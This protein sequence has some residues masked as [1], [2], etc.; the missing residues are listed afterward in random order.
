VI[1]HGSSWTTWT[2]D[3]ES[4]PSPA[5]GRSK[6]STTR[7][8]SPTRPWSGWSTGPLPRPPRERPRLPPARAL[9]RSPASSSPREASA[10]PASRNSSSVSRQ[11]S[12]LPPSFALFRFPGTD[13]TIFK[14]FSQ[15]IVFFFAQ[16]T[17]SFFCKNWIVTLV[18]EKNAN[19]LANFGKNRKNLWS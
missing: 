13:V 16:T 8:P 19:V 10:P 6:S 12:T 9:C 3:P 4:C 11:G 18:F 1:Q 15:K 5:A 7:Q 2:Q 14:I 17:A